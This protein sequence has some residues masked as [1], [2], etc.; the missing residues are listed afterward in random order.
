MEEQKIFSA[1][2]AT[3]GYLLTVVR[4]H[5]RSRVYNCCTSVLGVV[6]NPR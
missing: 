4:C 6:T 1:A 5:H 3:V 2:G